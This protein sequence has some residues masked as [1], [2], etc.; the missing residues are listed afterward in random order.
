MLNMI[1]AIMGNT[2]DKVI[3]KKEM[4]AM[5]VKIG[6]LSEYRHIINRV[7]KGKKDFSNFIFVVTPDIDMDELEASSDW[8]GGFNFLR[9]ALFRRMDTLEKV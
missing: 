8:E 7:N 3:E 1:I 4:A 6:I 2:F 5:N 9:K